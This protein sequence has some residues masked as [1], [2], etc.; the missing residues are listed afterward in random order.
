MSDIIFYG[1]LDGKNVQGY[2]Y[3]VYDPEGIASAITT[4]CGGGHIPYVL[5]R[6]DKDDEDE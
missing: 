5:T 2:K 6:E 3:S 4:G 1:N